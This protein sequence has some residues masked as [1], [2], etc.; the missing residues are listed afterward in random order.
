MQS[1]KSQYREKF[2]VEGFVSKQPGNTTLIGSN[3]SILTTTDSRTLFDF[4]Q[5]RKKNI[6]LL[7][8]KKLDVNKPIQ[9]GYTEYSPES[10]STPDRKSYY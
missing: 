6:Y 5:G 3:V 2:W 10:N 4:Y 8:E 7:L 1:T 9:T